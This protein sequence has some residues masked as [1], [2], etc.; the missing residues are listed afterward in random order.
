MV[1][2]VI[3]VLSADRAQ[4]ADKH[5]TV[6][7]A[8][9]LSLESTLNGVCFLTQNLNGAC[10]HLREKHSDVFAIRARVTDT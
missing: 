1:T 7:V 4:N 9:S 6:V 2:L 10:K 5:I 8:R 3:L